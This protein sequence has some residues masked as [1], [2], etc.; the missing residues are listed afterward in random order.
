MTTPL[1]Q[2]R[3]ALGELFIIGFNGPELSDETSAFLS[4][5]GIGGVMINS[6]NYESPGQM[7]ELSNQIQECRKGLPRWV[8]VDHEGGKHGRR[9]LVTL[10]HQA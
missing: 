5:A 4:Q 10:H 1:D 7:A 8:A 2:A 9:S 3:E 6:E